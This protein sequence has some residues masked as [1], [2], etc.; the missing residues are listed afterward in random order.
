MKK[1]FGILL[2]CLF[3]VGTTSAQTSIVAGINMA[4]FSGDDMIWDTDMRLGIRVGVLGKR[5]LSD[6]FGLR[7]G[8]F[9]SVKGYEASDVYFSG[10]YTNAI[11]T[12][13]YIE[14]PFGFYF[15]GN[16]MISFHA[17]IY[18]AFL[19][20]D[21]SEAGGISGSADAES[22]DMGLDF[23]AT[24]SVNDALSI[25]AGYQYGFISIDD[26]TSAPVD[27]YNSNIVIAMGYSFGGY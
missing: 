27:T 21:K 11:G 16:D 22:V 2:L 23:G 4:N 12:I 10:V 7:G 14:A 24:F 20:S 6:A 26:D 5:A 15:S 3:T 1:I 25:N 13:S 18:S 19:V 9:Y 17:G 8:V